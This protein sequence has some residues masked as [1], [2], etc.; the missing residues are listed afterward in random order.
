MAAA[1]AD[2]RSSPRVN[3]FCRV[4]HSLQRDAFFGISDKQ[5]LHFL[6]SPMFG[7]ESI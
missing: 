1:I 2:V 6:W 4:P 5:E 7:T 3:T